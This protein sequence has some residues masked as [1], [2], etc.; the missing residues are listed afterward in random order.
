MDRTDGT[1]L[2]DPESTDR[3]VVRIDGARLQIEDIAAVAARSVEV[4]LADA[5]LEQAARSQAYADAAALR[6]PLYG[7]TTGVGANRTVAIAGDP[8]AHALRLL[9]SHAT[10][11]GAARSAPRVRAMLTIRLNQLAAGGSGVDPAILDALQRMIAA[12]ALPQ[13]RALGSIGTGDLSA[14]ATTAL[15]LMGEQLTSQPLGEPVAFGAA[16][17][18]AFISSNA[19][20]LG[21]AALAV[22][23]LIESARAALVIGALTFEAVDGNA[24][25]YS[26]AVLRVTPFPG[27][28]VVCSGLRRLLGADR[29][30]V[31]RD[32]SGVEMMPARIQD[33][34]GLRAVAQVHGPVLD[35]LRSAAAVIQALINAP[36]ENPL[37]LAESTAPDGGVVAHHAGF[38]YVYLQMALDSL[39][40]AVAQSGQLIVSRLGMLIEPGFTGLPAFLG[41]GTPGA[42]GVMVCE[43]VAAS[44]LGSM[45]AAAAPA[46]LQTATLSRGVEEDASF[47]SLAA[48]D[49]LAVAEL[50][51][52]LLACE[53]VTAVRAQRMRGTPRSGLVAAV[54]GLC[55]VLPAQLVDR[56]LSADLSAAAELIPMLAVVL[57]AESW[58]GP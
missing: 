41:D 37:V 22:S 7:R 13:V 56:D 28:A 44:A 55:T 40:L 35:A 57:P 23:S 33:P 50:Y 36:S 3:A 19:A 38:H 24:E 16:D 11:S 39:A 32:S 34:F 14:L 5:G 51:R 2:V 9:R 42:S 31:R 47:A 48:E 58:V 30:G 20:A 52:D 49:C 53:L 1:A 25:A 6:R 21:D 43:Y 27:A 29:Y 8:G 54:L 17:G 26:D 12:D 10:S 45:K 18:L 4:Q 15:A 46:G